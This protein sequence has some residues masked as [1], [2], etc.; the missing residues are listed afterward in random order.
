M[1][2]SVTVVHRRAALRADPILRSRLFANSRIK[3]IWNSIVV[4]FLGDE[5]SG[6]TGL[7]LE[8]N[9]GLRSDLPVAGA[10][11]AIGHDPATALSAGQLALDPAGYILTGPNSTAASVPG[12]FTAGDVQDAVFRQAVTAAGSGCMAALEAERWL[13]SNSLPVGGLIGGLAACRSGVASR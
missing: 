5:A 13:D 8:R 7:L 2:T 6:L 10:F 9:D 11:V 1:A 3:V 4:A 12:V